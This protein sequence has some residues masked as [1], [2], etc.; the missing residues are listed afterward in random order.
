MTILA[1]IALVLAL[2]LAKVN[3]KLAKEN[4]SLERI[5][6]EYANRLSHEKKLKEQCEV[7]LAEQ[8][9]RSTDFA[10]GGL[11]KKKASLRSRCAKGYKGRL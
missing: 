4:E 5:T 3:S 1:L 10:R 8:I 6:R 9:R 11:P 2:W 7:A